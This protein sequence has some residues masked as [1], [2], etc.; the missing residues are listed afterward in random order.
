MY[1]PKGNHG[2][3]LQERIMPL[4]GPQPEQGLLYADAA[5]RQTRKFPFVEAPLRHAK[6]Y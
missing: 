2:P 6:T 3:E 5:E 4:K 1:E